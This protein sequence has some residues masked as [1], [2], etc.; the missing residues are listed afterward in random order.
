[1]LKWILI[2]LV[3]FLFYRLA[4]GRPRYGRLF[5]AAHL[6]EIDRGIERASARATER[7]GE[8]SPKDPFADG[9][10]FM[11]TAD[12]AVF[13]TIAKAPNGTF[14]H[15]VSLSYRGGPFARAAGGYL[16]AAIGRLLEI[17]LSQLNLAESSSGVYHLIF[18]LSSAAQER[19]SKRKRAHLDER[20]ASELIPVAMDDRDKLLARLGKINVDVD[21]AEGSS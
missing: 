4:K 18:A 6:M 3:V 10:A 13:Y 9:C 16:A 20:R 7:I 5:S 21:K 8:A 2:G 15:H 1:M 14:E 19:F 12:I 11:T 17:P